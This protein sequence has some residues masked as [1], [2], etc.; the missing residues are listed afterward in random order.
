MRADNI[1]ISLV[2]KGNEMAIKQFARISADWIYNIIYNYVQNEQDA[3][4]LTQDAILAALKN[5][6]NFKNESAIKTWVTSIALNKC[7]DFI[8]YKTRKKRKGYVFSLFADNGAVNDGLA[9]EFE[10]PGAVLE[11]KE[12]VQL[13][14]D[15]IN[16]LNENQKTA[17]I[18]AKLDHKSQKE[19]SEVMNISTKAVESLIARAKTNLKKILEAEGVEIYKKIKG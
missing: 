17:L 9:K 12:Q 6:A 3:E 19:I 1:D 16:Q 11:S 10:H 2:I 5:I 15:A 18:L 13:L 14:F 7:K 4:E 8:K